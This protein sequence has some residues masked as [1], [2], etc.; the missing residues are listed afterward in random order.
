MKTI[1]AG[2]SEMQAGMA[3]V[4]DGALLPMASVAGKCQKLAPI[5]GEN[6]P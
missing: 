5:K 3:K 2:C 1:F 6:I 4:V